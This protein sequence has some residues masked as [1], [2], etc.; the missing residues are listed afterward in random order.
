MRA[1]LLD[2]FKKVMAAKSYDVRDVDAGREYV[3]AYVTY[4]HYVEG[5]YETAV[6]PA[7]GHFP[8]SGAEPH[9]DR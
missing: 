7:S 9:Q 4:I 1:G 2:R 8:E 6:R 3:E 5:M